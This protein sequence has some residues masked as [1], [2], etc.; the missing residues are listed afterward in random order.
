MKIGN[1]LAELRKEKGL[2][3]EELGKMV[4]TSGPVIGRYERNEITPSVEIAKKIADAPDASLDYLVG[5]ASVL[6][7]DKKMAYRLEFLEKI[8][9]EDRKTILRVIDSFLKE[10]QT[11]VV[12]KQIE[13]NSQS[14]TYTELICSCYRPRFVIYSSNLTRVAFKSSF[15][16]D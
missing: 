15:S 16:L 10:A 11:A 12:E 13:I 5:S 9:D 4:G 7:K 2:S 14:L 8:S 3:R 6:V 1:K